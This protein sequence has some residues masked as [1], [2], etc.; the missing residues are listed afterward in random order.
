MA[1]LIVLVVPVVVYAADEGP[2]TPE[3]GGRI[4]APDI[5][6]VNPDPEPEEGQLSE[7]EASGSVQQQSMSV[8]VSSEAPPLKDISL[9]TGDASPVLANSLVVPMRHQDSLDASC[10][11]Y[12]NT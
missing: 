5:T 3:P 4:T 6:G 2:P 10:G 11:V 1:L 7:I 8:P 12:R 9:Q